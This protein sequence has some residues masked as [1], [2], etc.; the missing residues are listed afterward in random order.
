MAALEDEAMK[1]NNYAYTVAV[2]HKAEVPTSN[3]RQIFMICKGRNEKYLPVKTA[4]VAFNLFTMFI[5]Y[6]SATFD[7]AIDEGQ[8]F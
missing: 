6:F 8:N 5:Y 3:V 7:W 1:K 4:Q 2:S